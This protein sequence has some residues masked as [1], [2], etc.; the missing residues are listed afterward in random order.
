MEYFIRSI[1]HRHAILRTL[2]IL[3]M[4]STAAYA[5]L[6]V[7]RSELLQDAYSD[8]KQLYI[9]ILCPFIL[10]IFIVIYMYARKRKN[11]S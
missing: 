3:L 7:P 2:V 9:Y 10:G 4:F 6:I 11:K 8:L 5:D 1:K